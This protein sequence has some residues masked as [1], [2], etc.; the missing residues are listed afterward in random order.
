MEAFDLAILSCSVAELKRLARRYGK[1]ITEC[2]AKRDYVALLVAALTADQKN[3]ALRNSL[4]AGRLSI[5]LF[6]FRDDDIAF[7]PYENFQVANETPQIVRVGE[8]GDI[9]ENLVHIV[10]AVADGEACF[11]DVHLQLRSGRKAAVVDS[12]YDPRSRVLQVRTGSALAKKIGSEWARLADV[13][14]ENAIRRLG[15][16]TL[17]DLMDFAQ[18]LGAVIDKC[19][20]EKLEGAGF[21][22]V[23]GKRDSRFCDDLVGT[24]DFEAFTRETEPIEYDLIFEWGE[25]RAKLGVG[26]KTCSLVFR[27]GIGEGVIRYVY[28]KLEQFLLERAR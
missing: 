24:G 2:R 27:N 17:P 26:L 16:T 25:E 21:R 11:T 22:E 28:E 12:F 18:V 10:W 9:L 3:Q 6:Q 4:L 1:R 5:S 14:F 7:Q 19:K 20:G 15:I 8:E 13:D 23:S